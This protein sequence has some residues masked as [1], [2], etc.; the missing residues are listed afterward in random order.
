MYVCVSPEKAMSNPG[1]WASVDAG[2]EP[3]LPNIAST[4]SA[5]PCP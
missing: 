4:L 2:T 3:V 1:D 5:D